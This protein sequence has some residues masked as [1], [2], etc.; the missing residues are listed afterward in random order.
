[1]DCILARIKK[2]IWRIISVVIIKAF[3]VYHVQYAVSSGLLMHQ[4]NQGQCGEY[5]RRDFYR[6]ALLLP[7]SRRTA[8]SSQKGVKMVSALSSC[9]VQKHKSSG[10][11]YLQSEGYGKWFKRNNR[12]LKPLQK[13]GSPEFPTMK[14]KGA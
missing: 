7:P 3:S 4:R 11:L 2:I 12:Y 9:F 1:M 5:Q 14:G 10:L 13:E 6:S 8:S